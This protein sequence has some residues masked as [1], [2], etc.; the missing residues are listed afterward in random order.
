MMCKNLRKQSQA[1]VA[2]VCAFPKSVFASQGRRSINLWGLVPLLLV[3]LAFSF[4]TS[5]AHAQTTASISGTVQDP[6]GAVIP[7]ALVTLTNEATNE[8]HKIESNGAGLYAF[9]SLAPGKY[10]LKAAAKGFK[11]RQVTGIVVNAGDALSPVLTLTV[12]SEATTVTVSADEEMIPV[13]NG[14]KVDVLSSADIDNLALRPGHHRAAQGTA[15]CNHHVRRPH[16][17]QPFIQR[18]QHY[19][20]AKLDRHGHRPQRRGQP[21]RHSPAV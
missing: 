15:R 1:C 13:E 12:G 9:P 6:S 19:R 18:H 14:S 8:S 20:A 16:A 21:Q 17:N 7:G 11:A 4:S 3:A 5:A 10:S 2:S